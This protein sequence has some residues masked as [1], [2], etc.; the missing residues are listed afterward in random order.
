MFGYLDVEKDKLV[1]GQRG[2]WQTF[3]CG[4]CFDTKARYGNFPR[5]FI[6]N[7]INFF[8]VLFHSVMNFEVEVEHKKCFSYPLK[9]RTVLKHTDLTDKLSVANVLLTYWNIYDDTVD[10]GSPVKASVLKI[11]RFAYAQAQ[12]DFA[13]LDQMLA[14]RYQQ[15]RDMEQ[16]NCDSIDRVADAF[17]QLA[18]NFAV[19]VLGERA[20]ELVQTLC[21]NLGKW[22]YLI[23]ALD[24]VSKDLRRHNYNP[25]VAHYS[26][27]SARQLAA[28]FDELQFEMYAV[29]NRIASAYNDLNL[30]LYSCI[31]N[32]VLYDSIRSKTNQVLS[33][34][35]KNK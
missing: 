13:E 14:T 19:L 20:T 35:K 17:A 16:V 15:L 10:G 32:N 24:D 25:F 6:S 9:K 12:Q 34:Y 27:N 21:Y 18:K 1:D 5:M 8:N 33:K 31:L 29:L 28:N 26:V 23:D 30:T 4:L 7:D 3:M 2:L 11:L 22:I